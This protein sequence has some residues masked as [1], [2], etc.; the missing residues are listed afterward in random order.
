MSE[1]STPLPAEAVSTQPAGKKERLKRPVMPDV[2][3]VKA[4]T[5]ALQEQSK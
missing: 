1:D 4:K 3:E 5:G 2:E